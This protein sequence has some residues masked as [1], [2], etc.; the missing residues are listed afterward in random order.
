MAKIDLGDR[1]LACLRK[2][3]TTFI[4]TADGAKLISN[5]TLYQAY[6]DEAYRLQILIGRENKRKLKHEGQILH[7]EC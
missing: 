7:T 2:Q 4:M 1:L 3:R 6:E 5:H